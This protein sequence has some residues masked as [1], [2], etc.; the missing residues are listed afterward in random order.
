LLTVWFLCFAFAGDC[1][2]PLHSRWFTIPR[3]AFD[4]LHYALMALTKIALLLFFLL[5]GSP[6]GSYRKRNKKAV[7]AGPCE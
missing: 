5:P 2:Y 4:T 1:I 3:P 6:S 7:I